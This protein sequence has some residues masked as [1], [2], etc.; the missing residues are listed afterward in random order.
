M[1]RIKF[2]FIRNWYILFKGHHV[3]S[4]PNVVGGVELGKYVHLPMCTG[5]HMFVRQIDKGSLY[6]YLGPSKNF[7]LS[8]A[9]ID[10]P[11]TKDIIRKMYSNL[12][13][14]PLQ[15]LTKDLPDGGDEYEWKLMKERK[16]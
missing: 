9:F 6:F 14:S 10:G 15:F 16:T 8:Y 3:L 7:S 12:K 1:K 2:W 4:I 13:E 11:K 5:K